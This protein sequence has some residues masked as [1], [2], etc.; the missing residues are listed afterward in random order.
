LPFDGTDALSQGQAGFI[1][2]AMPDDPTPTKLTWTSPKVRLRVLFS[3]FLIAFV[4]YGFFTWVLWP[5]QVLGD[6]MLP[7]YHSGE[8]H[9]INKLAYRTA[10]P[11]R[12]DVVALYAPNG[13][14]YLKRVLG[15]PGETVT[16]TNGSLAIDGQ[17]LKEPYVD[18]KIVPREDEEGKLGPDDY[19]VIG[20]NRATSVRGKVSKQH[21]IGKVV[22]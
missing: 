17:E 15:L 14:V 20:D 6:S 3:A 8:R 13:D 5:V 11:Q 7:N 2:R 18:T 21:I 9:F 16:F 22:F 12:G 4:C 10:K 1:L 19:Y